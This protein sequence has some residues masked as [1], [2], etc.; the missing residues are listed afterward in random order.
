MFFFYESLF[1]SIGLISTF[2]YSTPYKSWKIFKRFQRYSGEAVPFS[3]S[4]L[5]SRITFCEVFYIPCPEK[6][7]EPLSISVLLT[8]P[9]L[10]HNCT[11]DSN[12]ILGRLL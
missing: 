10:N 11:S 6:M 9:L 3:L 1:Y 7:D 5:S 12:L 8:L 4:E 2:S